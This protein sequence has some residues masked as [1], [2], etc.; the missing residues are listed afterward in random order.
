MASHFSFPLLPVKEIRE[1]LKELNILISED[2]LVNPAGWKV[3]QMY[4]Q[5]LELLLGQRMQD[6]VQPSFAGSEELEYPELH[7]ESVPMIAFLKAWCACGRVRALPSIGRRAVCVC[8]CACACGCQL[9]PIMTPRHHATMQQCHHT[10]HPDGERIR[11]Q[12]TSVRCTHSHKLLSTS[13]ITDFTLN[14]V[15]KPDPKRLRRNLSAIINFA[16]FREDRQPGYVE[17]TQETDGL[18]QQKVSRCLA[19]AAA[20]PPRRSPRPRRRHAERRSPQATAPRAARSSQWVVLHAHA[21]AHGAFLGRQARLEEENERLVTEVSEAKRTRAQ[22]A[23]EE[24]ALTADNAK[25]EVVVRTLF[26]QQTEVHNEC[27]TL[28][29][30]LHQVQDAIREANF[31]LLEAKEEVAHLAEQ[32][33][34]DPRKLKCDLAALQVNAA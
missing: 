17:F 34:P 11:P 12:P 18:A 22:E 1:T 23:P 9:S 26:N 8:A 30:Q 6:M 2:D 15:N 10:I 29:A 13:G 21:H 14:D 24:S 32:I 27:Q 16:K 4:E 19:A 3:K 7:E 25:R 28:K 31:K 33:V 5:L 20:P